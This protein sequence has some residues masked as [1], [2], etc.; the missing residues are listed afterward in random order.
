MISLLI[1]VGLGLAA[2]VGFGALLA[3]PRPLR[4]AN[5]ILPYEPY[6][7][8]DGDAPGYRPQQPAP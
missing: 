6:A 4:D 2:A 3:E 5:R 8:E 1:I 7:P